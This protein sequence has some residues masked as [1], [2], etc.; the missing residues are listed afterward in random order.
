MRKPGH[1]C[2]AGRSPCCRIAEGLAVIAARDHPT[3]SEEPGQLPG[4]G[5]QE[6][7]ALV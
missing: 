7:E 3:A 2:W 4:D 5:Q 6:T 1:L